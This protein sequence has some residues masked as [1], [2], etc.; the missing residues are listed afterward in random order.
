[1]KQYDGNPMFRSLKVSYEVNETSFGTRRRHLMVEKKY[2]KYTSIF[3]KRIFI[4]RISFREQLASFICLQEWKALHAI[5]G[6]CHF[7]VHN[8]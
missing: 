4:G 1:M 2:G 3:F 8:K 6:R 5:L 7:V